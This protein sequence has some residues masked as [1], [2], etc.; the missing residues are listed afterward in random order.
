[1]NLLVESTDPIP[2]FATNPTS[3]WKY[4]SQF[5]LDASLSSDVDAM[6]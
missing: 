1:M 5:V 6:N 2:Q 4:P 3:L